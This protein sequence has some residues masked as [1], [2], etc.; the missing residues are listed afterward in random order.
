[1]EQ[2]P[3]VARGTRFVSGQGEAWIVKRIQKNGV[4]FEDGYVA[5]FK[6]VEGWLENNPKDDSISLA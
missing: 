4:L 3:L 1:M 6:E 2:E 5:T